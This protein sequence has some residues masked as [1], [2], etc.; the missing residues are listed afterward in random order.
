M[1]SWASL[2]IQWYR[3]FLPMPETQV[4]PLSR[5]DPTGCEQLSRCTAV[6]EPALWSLETATAEPRSREP[7]Q[8]GQLPQGEAPAL[9]EE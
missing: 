4:R 9:R 5:E 1:S 2:V 3:I 6:T 8:Q 7:L